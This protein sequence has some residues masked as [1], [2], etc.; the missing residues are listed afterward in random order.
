MQDLLLDIKTYFI[1]NGVSTEIYRDAIGDDPDKAIVLYE[2]QGASSLAQIDVNTRPIQVVTRAKLASEAKEEA[3]TLY[4]LLKTHDSII[5]FT[6]DR[7]ALIYLNHP[8]F[9]LKVDDR[10]RTYY[11]FNMVLT[12]YLE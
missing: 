6:E 11:A 12:T 2:Y 9:K 5:N 7:W 10:T 4:K 1:A 3:K 8:P